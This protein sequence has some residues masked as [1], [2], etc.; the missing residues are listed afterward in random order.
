MS[1]NFAEVVKDYVGQK[2]AVMCARYQYRG[3][4]S[5]VNDECLMLANACAVEVSGQSSADKPTTEEAVG[6]TLVI[7]NDAIEIFY[8]PNWCNAKLPNE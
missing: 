3:I 1:K 2:C 6:A 7:K 5:E 4:L 8:Q